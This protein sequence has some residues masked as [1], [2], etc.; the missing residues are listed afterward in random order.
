M[1][2][3]IKISGSFFCFFIFFYSPIDAFAAGG[4]E[5][6]L[7]LNSCIKLALEKNH[8]VN[9]AFQMVKK[10]YAQID[11]SS[12]SAWPQLDLKADYTRAGNIA[13]YDF[14]GEKISFGPEDN[15]NIGLNMTQKVYSPQ[16]FEA[17][18]AS[19]SFARSAELEFSIV[20]EGVVLSVKEAF[21]RYLFTSAMIDVKKEA[22]DQLQRHVNNERTRLDVGLAT[23]Y[24]LLRAEV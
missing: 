19:K 12:A 24:D 16:V 20:K 23:D 17:I 18:K 14:G 15:Y 3:F 1:A 5:A 2:K 10:A 11:E 22:V 9:S 6:P 21:Y 8:R 13:E 4:S 7:D